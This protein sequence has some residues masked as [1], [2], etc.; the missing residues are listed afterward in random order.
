MNQIEKDVMEVIDWGYADAELRCEVCGKLLEYD[1]DGGSETV[2]FSCP[3]YLDG[4]EDHTSYGKNF[5]A[6]IDMMK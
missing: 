6:V 5:S 3:E 2:W 1:V 4:H